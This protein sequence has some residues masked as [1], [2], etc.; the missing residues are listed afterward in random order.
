MTYGL[1]EDLLLPIIHNN[2]VLLTILVNTYDRRDIAISNIKSTY[3][4]TR[5]D[6]FL[7]I[8]LIDK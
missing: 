3:L 7:I 1:K 5:I 2:S 4:N 8:K 6:T